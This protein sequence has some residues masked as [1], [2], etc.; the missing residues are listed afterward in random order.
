P[1][2][3]FRGAVRRPRSPILRS[4][5]HQR[6]R[7]HVLI[8]GGGGREHALCHALARSPRRP[9][10][11]CAPGNAGTATLAENVALDASD[12]D[13]LLAFARERA[14]DLTI[15]GPEAPLVA[16]LVDRFEA[17]G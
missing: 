14:V 1:P 4:A 13:G 5:L 6:T 7:M 15:V 9:A 12:I 10:L 17:A 2:P 11:S 8:I 3:S 16:G